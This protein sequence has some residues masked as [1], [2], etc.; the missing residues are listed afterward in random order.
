MRWARRA[1]RTIE[2]A[3]EEIFLDDSLGGDLDRA[4]FEGR[5][6]RPLARSTFLIA[7]AGC[8]AVLSIL[9]LRAGYLQVVEGETYALRSAQNSLE[10]TTLF[11]PRGVITDRNGVV[12]VQNVSKEDG[13]MVRH[14]TL[15]EMG[16]IIG[17][18]S[19]PKKDSK[20][21]YY[22]F[23]QTGVVGLEAMYNDLLRGTNGKVLVE[24]DVRGET[25]SSG[26][27]EPAREGG[28]LVLSIDAAVERDLAEA[29]ASTVRSKNFI[30]GAGV[31]MDVHTGEVLAI[32]SYPSYDPNVMVRGGPADVIEGYST[33]QGH[34]FLDHAVQG[35]YTPGSIVKPFVSLGALTDGLI[36]AN[37]IINDPG[38][39][40]V[41]NP[42]QP[43]KNYVYRGWKPLGPVDVTLAIAWSSDIF[44]YTVGGGFGSQKG[45]G[46]DRLNYWYQ[47]FGFGAPTGIDLPDEASGVL[48]TPAHKKEKFNESW[49]LGDTYFTSI[50]QYSMQVTPIQAAR[51]AAAIANGGTLVRPTIR[52]G[53][54][55][56]ATQVPGTPEAYALVQ[57]GMRKTVTEALAQLLNVPYVT[58]AAKTGTAQ[59]GTRNQYDNSWVTGYFPY[60]NPQ[61]SFAIVL[62]RGPEG[63]GSQAVHA[64][65]AF[66]DIQ[67]AHNSVYVGG[68]GALVATSTVS[69]SR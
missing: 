29:I 46:I 60:E 25:R 24:Q 65:R 56:V 27:I 52:A 59:T 15:P 28:T 11:A 4:R 8:I 5:I 32:V 23:E 22:D 16:Q 40:T 68:S 48:A 47:Q 66:L 3:P 64:M 9:A 37:T 61:Y 39:M 14:Y 35:M 44:F 30:A 62:E 43:G 45:L 34:P 57:K 6:E 12:I 58:V 20:G 2:I 36:S 50:G 67:H 7:G 53:Q 26:V 17:Y 19:R 1:R 38:S 21:R 55:T 51:A 31:I 41:P 10:T 54:P 33:S 42:Y 69:V 18:V 13:E 63:V 49:Y